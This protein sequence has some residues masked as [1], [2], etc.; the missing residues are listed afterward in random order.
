MIQAAHQ[1]LSALTV[2]KELLFLKYNITC[3]FVQDMKNTS[4]ADLYF[5]GIL[6]IHIIKCLQRRITLLFYA[7]LLQLLQLTQMQTT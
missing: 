3:K 4:K 6:K 1:V 7:F 2:E 5:G